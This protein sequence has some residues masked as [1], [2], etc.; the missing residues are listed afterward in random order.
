MTLPRKGHIYNVRTKKYMG[1]GNTFKYRLH[2]GGADLFAVLKKVACA[3]ASAAPAEAA[4]GSVVKF[5]L[6]NPG[7]GR[8]FYCELTDPA[9]KVRYSCAL[10]A[11]DGKAEGAF[12]IAFN[13]PA[14]K[15]TFRFSDAASG[16]QM[17][18]TLTV[19]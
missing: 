1:Y 6:S 8:V 10:S 3:P 5:Q 7:S 9:G 15:W 4:R 19:K 17:T 12:Q 16:A 18:R 2:S 13:D 11:P 14:G